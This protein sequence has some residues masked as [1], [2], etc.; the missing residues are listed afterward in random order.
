MHVR[1]SKQDLTGSSSKICWYH[2]LLS[3][4]AQIFLFMAAKNVRNQPTTIIKSANNHNKIV[5]QRRQTAKLW[6]I[7]DNIKGLLRWSH[8]H[9]WYYRKWGHGYGFGNSEYRLSTKGQI[10]LRKEINTW[11]NTQNFS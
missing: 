9:R 10:K 1:Q 3:S 8:N 4:G 11:K 5:T 6:Q 7:T 2:I